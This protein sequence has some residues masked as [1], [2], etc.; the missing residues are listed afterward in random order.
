VEASLSSASRRYNVSNKQYNQ[1]IINQNEIN[2]NNQKTLPAFVSF[3]ASATTDAGICKETSPD[4][5]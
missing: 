2:T 1:T 4:E 5:I 3:G